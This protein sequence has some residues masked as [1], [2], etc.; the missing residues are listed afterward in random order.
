MYWHLRFKI[1]Q[2]N[3]VE[4]N[5]KPL[6]PSSLRIKVRYDDNFKAKFGADAANT[7][8]RVMAQVSH[9]F[10]NSICII[11]PPNVIIISGANCDHIS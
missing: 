1:I 3:N 6:L 7:A 4:I 8:R 9:W 5:I 11:L 10:P 2:I